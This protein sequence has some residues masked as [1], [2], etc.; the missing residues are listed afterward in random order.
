MPEKPAPE[1]VDNPQTLADLPRVPE[2]ALKQRKLKTKTQQ[3]AQ[4]K[5]STITAKAVRQRRQPKPINFKRL[6]W[7]VQ[8]ANRREWERLRIIK[9]ARKPKSVQNFY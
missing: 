7:F 2:F 8:R 3:K 9:E 4:L 5:Q 1:K 6:E